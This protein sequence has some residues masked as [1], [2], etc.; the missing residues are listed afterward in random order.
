MNIK[1]M[2]FL[3]VY[4]KKALLS[5]VKNTSEEIK[6]EVFYR[7]ISLTITSLFYL[8]G[9]N[10]HM[11][12]KKMFFVLCI[13]ISSVI[14]TYLYIKN[15]HSRRNIKLMVLIET[16]GNSLIL[17]PS[18]GLSSPYIWYAMNTIL[19][20]SLR[21]DRINCWINLV[22]YI[23]CSTG[24]AFYF[25]DEK[26]LGLLKYITKGSYLII[27]FIIITG[28]IQ[29]LADK[30]KKIK[31]EQKE[32]TDKNT[33]LVRANNQIK[34]SME[35]VMFFYQIVH[36]FVNHNDRNELMKMLMRYTKKITKAKVVF[37]YNYRNKGNK[38]NESLFVDAEDGFPIALKEKLQTLIKERMIDLDNNYNPMEFN[39]GQRRF[40]F[41]GVNSVHKKYG[42][43]GIEV[44]NSSDSC[45]KNEE[46]VQL[47]F[48]GE[49]GSI[50]FENSYMEDINAEL[51]VNEEQN[52]MA[53]EIHDGVMQRLFGIASGIFLLIR[54]MEEIPM[55]EMRNELNAIRTSID[56]AMK[57]LRHTIYDFSWGKNGR[58]AFE[59]NIEN[60]IKEVRMMNNV[61][62]TYET[63]G[64]YEILPY[65]YKKVFY[66]ILSE[67]ISNAL[68]HGE[69]SKIHIELDIES[70][71]ISLKIVDNGVGFDLDEVK[72]RQ[73]SGLGIKNICY[74]AESLNGKTMIDS[75]VGKGTTIKTE[76]PN[77]FNLIK[78]GE[79]I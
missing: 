69:A 37:F 25:S 10:N 8:F 33:Q 36:S 49:L 68:R 16:V 34:E 70:E 40:V 50:V 41:M 18:G 67:V 23:F 45:R 4:G 11:I 51:L 55:E 77:G 19:I 1:E 47:K 58:N 74:L 28:I 71:L 76:I 61:S 64:K 73:S 65:R 32:L 5:Q 44:E 2:I 66:R 56:G 75:K 27:S 17:I 13:S 42:F 60:Y 46:I 72:T 54:K 22:I 35:C 24:I 3:T 79:A 15:N 43:I 26:E 12:G 39:I 6:I 78:E 30:L 31:Y 38:Q 59:D 7:Y 62:I 57:E 9:N 21:L 48:M 63:N 29:L 52:R 14:L 20:A 53:N